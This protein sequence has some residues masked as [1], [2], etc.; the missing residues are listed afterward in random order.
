M[1]RNHLICVLLIGWTV[2]QASTGPGYAQTSSAAREFSCQAFPR[3]MGEAALIARFG[4]KNVRPAPVVGW[5]DGPQDGTVVFPVREDLKL[6]VFWR[7]ARREM[8]SVRTRGVGGRWQSPDGITVGMDLKTIEQR[9]G[10]PFR[11][12]AFAGEGYPG[13]ILSWG[14]GRLSSKGP[15]PCGVHIYLLPAEGAPRDPKMRL[16]DEREFSSAHPV[17]QALNPRVYQMIV[18]HRRP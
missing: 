5:D 13:E 14:K 16:P 10:A 18:G 4:A 11:L 6:E 17:I 2:D 8:D 3:E 12:S 1:I 7:A 15:A 9:N